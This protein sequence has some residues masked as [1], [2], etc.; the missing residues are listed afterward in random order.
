MS[1]WTT[2]KLRLFIVGRIITV[3]GIILLIIRGSPILIGMIIVGIILILIGL[4]WK[5]KEKK[6]V[7]TSTE[8]ENLEK[9]KI[10]N[11]KRGT[12]YGIVLEFKIKVH[13]RGMYCYNYR[14]Y[15][16]HYT[17]WFFHF[18]CTNNRGNNCISDRVNLET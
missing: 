3:L 1:F 13:I 2:W 4:I 7:I 15:I 8:I 17:P 18:L 5:P 10:E 14:R 6:K 11:K 12:K 16:A 9:K